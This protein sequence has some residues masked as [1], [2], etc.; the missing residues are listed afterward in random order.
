MNANCV[1]ATPYEANLHT[2]THRLKKEC[3]VC[4]Q[5]ITLGELYYSIWYCIGIDAHPH[6]THVQELAQFAIKNRDGWE[7]PF[8][9]KEK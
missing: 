4:H 6:A 7:Y 3:C 2:A 9:E 1:Q 5:R 8:K